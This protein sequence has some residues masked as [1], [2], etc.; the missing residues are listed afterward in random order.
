MPSESLRIISLNDPSLFGLPDDVLQ[1]G[2]E[3]VA[4]GESK[5]RLD[6]LDFHYHIENNDALRLKV[7]KTDGRV[8][9][10]SLDADSLRDLA[11][12][13][14][15]MKFRRCRNKCPFC[16]VDQM[17]KGLRRSLYLKDEDYRLSFLYGNYTTLNDVTDEDLE[18]IITENLHPQF[19]SVHAV[20]K[21]IRE[22][23]FGRPLKND[24]L[25]TLERLTSNGITVHAQ[26]VL[27]PGLNDGASLVETIEA[28]AALDP[29]V[30]SL[31]VV[32]VGLT[33]HRRNLPPLRRYEID[34]YPA[35]IQLIE[36][37]QDK[38]LA[39]ERR[40]RFVF[41]SDEWYIASGHPL[42]PFESYESFAQIDNG[43][44]MTRD[45]L[46]GVA[47]DIESFGIPRRLSKISIATGKLGAGIFHDYVFP[48]LE[49]GGV[50]EM[51]RVIEVRNEFFGEEVTVSG[52]LVYEDLERA[53]ANTNRS[54]K[55]FI[56]PNTLNFESRFIDGPT[57]HH[58][59]E[60][61][62]ADVYV[63]EASLVKTLMAAVDGGGEDE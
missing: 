19:V 63:P 11:I 26:V 22:R 38:F 17:P 33:R 8:E 47:S 55:I 31:S 35:I 45:F 28:L 15:P 56:P 21:T 3:I 6:Q 4:I 16:F 42:P 13:F 9:E 51:P 48:I 2:D 49:S 25:R 61:L 30:L 5:G 50:Q 10:L 37:Y 32:P 60:V 7:K 14:T 46:A 52:L 12:R 44:G 53:L 54:E 18:K 59:R 41:L 39:S 40:S 36:E 24:I 58:L 27:C 62:R 34:E 43:V 23:V 57:L 20:D 29:N 1:V